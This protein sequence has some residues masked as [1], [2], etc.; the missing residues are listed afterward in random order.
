MALANTLA[1]RNQSPPSIG[2][3]ALPRWTILF[4]RPPSSKCAHRERCA[5]HTI[6][7]SSKHAGMKRRASENVVEI[8]ST[9]T[10]RSEEAHQARKCAGELRAVI[11]EGDRKR[12]QSKNDDAC[13][14]EKPSTNAMGNLGDDGTRENECKRSYACAHIAQRNTKIQK[15][16]DQEQNKYAQS[17]HVATKNSET[18]YANK[19]TRAK[20]ASSGVELCCADMSMPQV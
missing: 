14:I 1:W 9:G 6:T 18:E 12:S 3:K 10:P 13:C 17:T 15:H 7:Y 5:W 11:R 4:T 19:P 2:T 16:R 8:S 20:R